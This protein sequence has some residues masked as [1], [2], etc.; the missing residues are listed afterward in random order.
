[1]L[2]PRGRIP[3]KVRVQLLSRKT[4]IVA[5]E[6]LA[7]LVAFTALCPKELCQKRVMHFIDSSAA[8]ACVVRGFSRQPDLAMIAGRLWFESSVLMLDYEA[9]YVSTH[10]N[11]A[12]GPSRN[13]VEL[14]MQMGA[15]EVHDWRFPSFR[16]GLGDWM[17]SVDQVGR[18]TM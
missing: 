6:L 11:I 14:L 1:M 13:D 9:H 10:L 16:E 5:F 8:L 7:A 15:S 3:R 2:F 4:N 12:D 18:I 17:A